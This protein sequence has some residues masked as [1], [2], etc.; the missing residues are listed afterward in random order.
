[1]MKDSESAQ[2]TKKH[3]Q[4][5]KQGE[6]NKTC[7]VVKDAGDFGKFAK[8]GSSK[9]LVHIRE[10]RKSFCLFFAEHKFE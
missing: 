9:D 5:E 7:K 4:V 6:L 10:I 8:S 2:V 1:M 3:A